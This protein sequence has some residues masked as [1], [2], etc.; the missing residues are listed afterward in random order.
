MKTHEEYRIRQQ[1][2]QFRTTSIKKV[3]DVLLRND[4]ARLDE[5]VKGIIADHV[6][7]TQTDGFYFD[8]RVY[9][10]VIGVP[11]AT[12]QKQPIDPSL[13]PRMLV[14]IKQ[15]REMD[16]DEAKIGQGLAVLLRKATN[17]QDVR[18][19]LPEPLV[20]VLPHLSQYERQRP[21][22]YGLTSKLHQ[23]QYDKTMDQI[24]FYLGSRLLG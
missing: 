20:K 5:L 9:T 6:A 16:A 23:V 17:D 21:A 4:R 12:L 19:A 13:K 8:G 18:D 10:N 7:L 15:M 3:L 24:Y 2:D 11:F 1:A 22:A 14:Y